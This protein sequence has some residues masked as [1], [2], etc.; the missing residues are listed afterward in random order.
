MLIN[1]NMNNKY[2]IPRRKS[3][4][5]LLQSVLATTVSGSLLNS[6][7]AV[8]KVKKTSLINPNILMRKIPK[9]DEMIPAIGLGSFETFDID[10]GTPIDNITEIIDLYYKAGGRIIDTSPLY[11]NSEIAIGHALTKLDL[12]D[13]VFIS[14]KIWATGNYLGDDSMA[15]NQFETS[16]QRLWCSSQD[17]LFVHSLVDTPNKLKLFKKLKD[18]GK[19]KYTGVAHW[20][21][22]AYDDIENVLNNYDIDFLQINY[23]II[24]RKVEERILPLAMEKGVAVMTNMAFEKARLFELVKNT[25][26][27]PFAKDLGITNW[28]D[29][30][31][32]YVLANPAVTCALIGT[33]NPNH[34]MQNLTAF[35]G[36]LPD[37]SMRKKMIEYLEKIPGYDTIMKTPPYLGKNYK[38][39]VEFPPTK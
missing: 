38:G 12:T 33:S 10:L 7:F 30:F 34:L 3:L 24:S 15:V 23:S 32:K 14:N 39:V 31:L 4:K 9:S 6:V 29:F 11:G 2:F 28:G 1:S 22:E 18:E 20:L 27:P 13:K 17:L 8:E 35:K 36:D 16:K 5:I 25:A 37:I 19:I 21:N 26:L